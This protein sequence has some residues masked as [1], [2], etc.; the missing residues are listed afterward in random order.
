MSNGHSAGGRQDAG[1][2]TL[3]VTVRRPAMNDSAP[4]WV[5]SRVAASVSTPTAEERSAPRGTA[6]TR[7]PGA[8]ER[9]L[10]NHALGGSPRTARGAR[11]RPP[12]LAGDGDAGRSAAPHAGARLLDRR[13]VSPRRGGGDPQ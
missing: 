6:R 2:S 5:T 4:R 10:E 1:G 8:T 9:G 11:A 3:A 12:R 7:T 13:R